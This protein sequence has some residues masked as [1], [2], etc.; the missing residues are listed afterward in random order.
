MAPKILISDKI[1]AV[2][3]ESFKRA[4]F[5]VDEKSGLTPEALGEIIG[6]YHGLVVRSATKVT[7]EILEKGAAGNLKIVG[8]AG[9][10]L[11]NI[12]GAAAQRLNVKVV[13]TP[14][15]NANAVAELTIGLIIILARKLWPAMES[16]KAGRW[17]KK[18]LGGYEIAGKTIGLLGLGAVGKLVA[19]KAIGLGLKVL[20]YDPIIGQKAIEA[21]GA[22][23]VG[24]E[25]LFKLSDY[26]SLHL[27]KTKETANIV[28][29]KVLA[30]MKP[31]SYLINCAR[32]GLVDEGALYAALKEKRLAGAATDVFDKE[33]PDPMPLMELANFVAIPHLG[34]STQ[35][36]QLA[37]AEKVALLIIGYLNGGE[38]SGLAG[39]V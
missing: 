38:L 32:G 4:G 31:T 8:R 5:E 37:V 9:A 19:A 14:G 36:A 10:G 27:P 39:G 12:D 30:L 35:E 18:N 15:L 26:L 21:V 22:Q 16:I 3:P 33:P 7:S 24:F 11:D 25:E 34:A 23:A 17:E 1:E 2:C 28:D 13:N 29:A 20:A 6:G